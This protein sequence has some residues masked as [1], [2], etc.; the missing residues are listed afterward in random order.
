[1]HREDRTRVQRNGTS[2]VPARPR[3]QVPNIVIYYLLAR[4]VVYFIALLRQIEF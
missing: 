1:M 3:L 2:L 4:S